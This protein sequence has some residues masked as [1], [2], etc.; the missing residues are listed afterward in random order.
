MTLIGIV[1]GGFESR[2]GV[3]RIGSPIVAEMDLGP[4]RPHFDLDLVA[5][6]HA[7]VDIGNALASFREAMMA[8]ARSELVGVEGRF[9]AGYMVGWANNKISV[10]ETGPISTGAA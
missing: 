3:D 8:E 6:H 5:A 4:R 2:L 9:E 7:M 10:V 1:D